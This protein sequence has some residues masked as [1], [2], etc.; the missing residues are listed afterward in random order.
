[1]KFPSRTSFFSTPLTNTILV[2][3]S[4]PLLDAFGVVMRLILGLPAWADSCFE[5]Q[6]DSRQRGSSSAEIE[7][8]PS[9][10]VDVWLTRISATDSKGLGAISRIPCPR[11]EATLWTAAAVRFQMSLRRVGADSVERFDLRSSMS[12]RYRRL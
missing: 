12:M 6:T 10:T 1:M 3:R 8:E 11:P 4:A 5:S 9:E 7:F 2:K